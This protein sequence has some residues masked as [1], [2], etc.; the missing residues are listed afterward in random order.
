MHTTNLNLLTITA[1]VRK[2]NVREWLDTSP[3]T[4]KR[5]TRRERA[6]PK[7]IRLSNAPN[8]YKLICARW[9]EVDVTGDDYNNDT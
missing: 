3:T 9:S 2:V 8:Y 4:T 1:S 5:L 6:H 7:T